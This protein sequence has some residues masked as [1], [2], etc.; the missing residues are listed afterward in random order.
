MTFARPVALV[1]ALSIAGLSSS[2]ALCVSACIED[3]PGTAPS[4]AC[5]EEATDVRLTSSS[6][7]C[8]HDGTVVRV[9]DFSRDDRGPVMLGEPA[10]VTLSRHA[11]G[12]AANSDHSSSSPIIRSISF[13]PILRI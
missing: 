9:V 12:P 8:A 10:V 1:L 5:H 2:F 4:H 6:G 13:S 7:A 11:Q 3:L